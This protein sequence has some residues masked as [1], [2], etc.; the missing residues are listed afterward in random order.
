[1]CGDCCELSEGGLKTFAVCTTCVAAGGRS[2]GPA[3]RGLVG[4]LLLIFVG[5]ALIAIVL[6]VLNR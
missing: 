4:W 5:F 2:L 6:M 3:W 1:V